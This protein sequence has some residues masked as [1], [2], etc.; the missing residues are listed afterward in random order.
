MAQKFARIAQRG[1]LV[2]ALLNA[3][4]LVGLSFAPPSRSGWS[5]VVLA[6]ANA[7]ANSQLVLVM[8]WAALG[9]APRYLRWPA[10][11]AALWL[12]SRPLRLVSYRYDLW[13]LYLGWEIIPHVLVGL[14]AF[15]VLRQCG[16]SI[17]LPECEED[18]H[19]ARLQFNLRTM[20]AWVCGAA[21]LTCAWQQLIILGQKIGWPSTFGMR[22]IV[23]EGASRAL[24]LTLIDL[25]ALW[26][27]LHRSPLRAS[28]FALVPLILVGQTSVWRWADQNVLGRGQAWLKDFAFVSSFDLLYLTPLLGVLLLARVAG[29]RLVWGHDREE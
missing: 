19:S 25:M 10:A 26:A 8:I 29:Y 4:A 22:E 11:G 17:R 3:T 28:Q 12:I 13:R 9:P 14:T 15:G 2:V 24:P 21:L 5:G 20:L 18:R 23:V 16:L 27:T 7:V 6:D 1:L